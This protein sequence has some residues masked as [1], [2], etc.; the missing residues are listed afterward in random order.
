[1][2]TER[3]M[4]NANRPERTSF[5]SR[6]SRP[7]KPYSHGDSRPSNRYPSTQG[8]SQNYNK[9]YQSFKG[10]TGKGNPIKGGKENRVS[11]KTD[12][13]YRKRLQDPSWSQVA[14]IQEI[15]EESSSALLGGHHICI[16]I[17][18][19]YECNYI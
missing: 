10:K 5:V 8:P 1:M 3:A 19:L 7:F 16:F 18:K 11:S 12:S 6:Q 2:W 13:N 17:C 14:S 9:T 4:G 15:V